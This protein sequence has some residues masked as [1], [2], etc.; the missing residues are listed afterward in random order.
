PTTKTTV[1]LSAR[2]VKG[3]S[4]RT[5]SQLSRPTQ[6]GLPRTFHSM[7]EI[8]RTPPSGTSAKNPKN[9]TAGSAI[10]KLGPWRRCPFAPPSTLGA[11]EAVAV[12]ELFSVSQL[13]GEPVT[14]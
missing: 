6:V 12:I 5:V 3:R 7:K 11:E 4:V 14:P 10:R 9:R 1:R 2:Q 13:S 8:T